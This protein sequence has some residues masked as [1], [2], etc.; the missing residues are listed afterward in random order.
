MFNFNKYLCYVC[1]VLL[2]CTSTYI[3]LI[4]INQIRKH[5]KMYKKILNVKSPF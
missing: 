5:R 1:Y 3:F 4:E 2:M